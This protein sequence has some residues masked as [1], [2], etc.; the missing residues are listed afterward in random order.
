[1]HSLLST[2]VVENCLGKHK[3][4]SHT[5]YV[6][7][8][9]SSFF[10]LGCTMSI[11]VHYFPSLLN[12][13]PESLSDL[14]E[15]QCA[16]NI[17]RILRYPHDVRLLMFCSK[18]LTWYKSQSLWKAD[19]VRYMGKWTEHNFLWF[20]RYYVNSWCK[21]SINVIHLH[22]QICQKTKLKICGH[23]FEYPIVCMHYN[24]TYII[25]QK[26]EVKEK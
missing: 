26:P 6:E 2:M 19:F 17:L 22:V 16:R 12:H 13:F 3:V 11:K 21:F 4:D 1:M 25:S 15:E 24:Q 20:F 5:E 7:R 8:I 10:K 23:Q 14:S 9:L 18:W